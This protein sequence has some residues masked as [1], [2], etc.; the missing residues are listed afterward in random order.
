[1]PDKWQAIDNYFTYANNNLN[2]TELLS[3]GSF[4][5]ETGF[6]VSVNSVQNGFNQFET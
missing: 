6:K 4:V 3:D 2:V 5:E 1:M